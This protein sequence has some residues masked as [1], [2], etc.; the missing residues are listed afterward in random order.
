M[1]V[2]ILS[3]MT[4]TQPSLWRVHWKMET[5][6]TSPSLLT[7]DI[8]PSL[9]S[10]MQLE[11]GIYLA[12]NSVRYV[13][14]HAGVSSDMNS[15]LPYGTYVNTLHVHLCTYIHLGL[16]ITFLAVTYDVQNATAKGDNEIE[17]TVHFISNSPAMG[18]LVVL[19]SDSGSPDEFRVLLRS[20]S[21]LTVSDM[22]SVPPSTYTLYVYDLEEDGHV[23]REPAI[24]PEDR[25]H[26]T[27]SC[28]L[29][30]KHTH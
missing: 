13:C 10:A 27:T 8:L 7:E 9:K 12:L 2:A 16:H 23:N 6:S 17:V 15:W 20:G 24:L 11:P 30:E 1:Y 21:D 4:M 19:Q 28:K 22:I 26:A 29:T 3:M 18:C 25:I 5:W 14:V